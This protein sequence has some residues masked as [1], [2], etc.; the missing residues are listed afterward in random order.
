[1]TSIQ[2]TVQEFTRWARNPQSY[3]QWFVEACPAEN[4]KALVVL[5]R[6]K[7]IDSAEIA[8]HSSSTFMG[9]PVIMKALEDSPPAIQEAVEMVTMHQ[10]KC[11]GCGHPCVKCHGK[12]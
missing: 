3:R 9:F 5:Y 8:L 11:P 2:E 1:M 12:L 6:P 4:M 7:W 10:M